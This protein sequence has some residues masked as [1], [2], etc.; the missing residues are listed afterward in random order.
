MT[1]D[2]LTGLPDGEALKADFEALLTEMKK[3]GGPITIATTDI[4]HFLKVNQNYGR[5][6]GDDVLK[7]V[8]KIFSAQVSEPVRVY[9]QRGDEFVI[10]FPGIHRE[11]AF[12]MM[13]QI[14]RAVEETEKYGDTEL[15]IKISGGVAAF[16]IDGRESQL[17][18]RKA[19]QA[20]YQAKVAGSNQIRLAYDERMVPKTVHFTE[21]QLE[22]LALLADELQVSEAHLLREA[23]DGLLNKY[24]DRNLK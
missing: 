5:D 1:I 11:Q 8:A 10:L 23:L 14:R 19:D 6:V 20:L 15:K 7:G 17:L 12:L 3:A 4:D 18:L 24:K 21:T 13:E 22:R 2:K 16:P 9:R